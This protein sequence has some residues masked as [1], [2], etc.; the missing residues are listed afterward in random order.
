MTELAPFEGFPGIGKA[1]AI[2][3]SFFSTVLPAM[4]EPGDLLAFLWVARLVQEQQGD[5]RFVTAA[6]IWVLPEAASSFNALAGGR[7][8]LERGLTAC[9]ECG[10]LLVLDLAGGGQQETVYFVNNSASRRAVARARGGDIELRPGAIAYEAQPVRRPNIFQLYEEHVGTITPLV[11]ERLL[12]AAD[13]YPQH[14]IESAFREAA[15]RNIR[16]WKYVERMLQNWSEGNQQHETSGRDSVERRRRRFLGDGA[17][18]R[19]TPN[20]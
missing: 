2:H 11:A 15:E 17:A 13:Q 8:S 7:E 9:V 1:T 4:R 12:V 16:N 3:N 6:Q 10:A 14:L 19:V 20:R 18:G 5:A